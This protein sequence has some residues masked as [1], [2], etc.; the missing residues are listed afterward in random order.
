LRFKPGF[1]IYSPHYRLIWEMRVKMR[2]RLPSRKLEESHPLSQ[3]RVMPDND[4]ETF[5]FP[6]LCIGP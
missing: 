6:D 2:V 1:A 5:L 4:M 3:V